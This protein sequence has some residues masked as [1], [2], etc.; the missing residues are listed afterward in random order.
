MAEPIDELK[1]RERSIIKQQ[2]S[3]TE[4]NGTRA[5]VTATDLEGK[6]NGDD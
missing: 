2:T 5:S 4:V 3:L 6:W 1:A